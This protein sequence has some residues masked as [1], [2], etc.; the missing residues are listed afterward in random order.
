MLTIL[1]EPPP[2]TNRNVLQ[3]L[4]EAEDDDDDEDDE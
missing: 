4:D 3:W 2:G 1:F